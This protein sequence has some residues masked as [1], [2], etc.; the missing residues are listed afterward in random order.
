MGYYFAFRLRQVELKKEV[1]AYLKSHTNDKHLTHFKVQLTEGTFTDER[2][3]WENETEFEFEGKMYDV[4]GKTTSDT[5]MVLHCLEDKKETELLRAFAAVQNNETQHSKSRTSSL[6]QIIS[7]V[8]LPMQIACV[9]E[10]PIAIRYNFNFYTSSPVER[11]A[12]IPT[13]PPQDC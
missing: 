12:D 3:A 11:T 13:P 9:P 6:L 8:Y 4:I 7:T 5:I 1:H 2:F 10:A